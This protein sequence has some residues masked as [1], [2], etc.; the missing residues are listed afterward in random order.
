MRHGLKF[1]HYGT[2][3]V[4]G[5][6]NT[7]GTKSGEEIETRHIDPKLPLHHALCFAQKHNMTQ[8]MPFA[9]CLEMQ[10]LLL[11]YLMVLQDLPNFFETEGCSA[12]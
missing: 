8:L 1:F 10:V 2:V 7:Q 12:T 4:T 5:W 6:S 9:C 3:S 11:V